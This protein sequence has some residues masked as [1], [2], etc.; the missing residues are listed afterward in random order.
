MTSILGIGTSALSAFRRSLTTIG[1]NIANVNTPGYSRQTVSLSTRDPQFIGVGY[2]G[3]GVQVSGIERAYSEFLD[4][5]S[6][7]A[8][9]AAAKF[10]VLA[11]FSGRIDN[12]VADPSSS[13][14]TA[15]NSFFGAVQ[16]FTT[17]PSSVAARNTVAAETENLIQ[18]FQTLDRS[19]SQIA[20]E[21]GNAIGE[22]VDQINQLAESIAELNNRIV[23]AGRE[24]PAND[25]LDQ[26]SQ[27][28]RELAVE[29]DVTVVSE[30]S[31]S[32]SLFI[33]NGQTLVIGAENYPLGV[34]P[35]EFDPTKSEVVYR[36]LAGDTPVSDVL[37]GG[38]IGALFEFDASVLA[39]SRRA[40]GATAAA[41]VTSLNQQN[42]QGLDADDNL[43][44]DLL[45]VGSPGVVGSSLNSGAASVTA[46]IDDLSSISNSDYRLINDG[47]GFRLFRGDTSEEITLSG[48]GSAGDPFVGGGLS[49]VVSGSADAG[50][51]FQIEPTLGAID[52]LNN[53][54]ETGR[55]L[56]AAAP[57]RGLSSPNN[58]SDASIDNG[59]IIDINDS[60]LFTT[61][62]IVFSDAT[63]YSVNGAGSF[64]LTPGT[65]ISINGAEFSISGSPAAGDQFTIE[66]NANATSDNRNALQLADVQ[67]LKI[68]NN[69][70]S[71]VG[72]AYSGL[73]AEIGSATRQA[74][75]S[76]DAQ[77]VLLQSAEARRDE[78]SGVD[79]DEEAADLI[80]YQ[81]SYQAAAQVISVASTLFDTLIAATRR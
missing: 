37:S 68:L 55:E 32:V 3:N 28:I 47:S 5:Q 43:G 66:R 24:F 50:D 26:R 38:T 44:G 51:Q 79:L 33:G 59:T 72:Q 12:L 27:L 49:I 15:L 29:V 75:S 58:V 52:G 8:G 78:V 69:G 4:T 80:R 13:L 11:G 34:R 21:S 9:S 81:Q 61:S 2:A 74:N 42:A 19:L 57:L 1:Q 30:S 6:R 18:R 46:T 62:Q 20:A 16:N 25:L 41:L 63:T 67:N 17:D 39:P 35:S 54:I 71:S 23:N 48:S 31:G 70:T 10:S 36:G 60:G 22:S 64:T 56:A 77:N 45:Q 53:L 65:P 7:T 40:L 73:V 14:S 76:A